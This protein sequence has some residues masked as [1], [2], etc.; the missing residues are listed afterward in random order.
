MVNQEVYDGKLVALVKG[1]APYCL[2]NYCFYYLRQKVI[3]KK[4][5]QTLLCHTTLI[6]VCL[7]TLEIVF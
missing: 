4:Q 7:L 2:Y 1:M 5:Q 3:P 6:L